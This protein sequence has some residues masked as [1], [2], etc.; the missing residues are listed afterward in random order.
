MSETLVIL[1]LLQEK[2]TLM[3]PLAFLLTSFSNELTLSGR[4]KMQE[5]DG[6]L[7]WGLFLKR[8]AVLLL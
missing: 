7:L 1:G 3:I 5:R 8:N 2:I 4:K 6:P